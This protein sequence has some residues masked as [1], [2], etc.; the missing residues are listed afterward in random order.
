MRQWNSNKTHLL[1]L[2]KLEKMVITVFTKS[3]WSN[4]QGCFVLGSSDKLWK[5]FICIRAKLPLIKSHRMIFYCIGSECMLFRCNIFAKLKL[6]EELSLTDV[7]VKTTPWPGFKSVAHQRIW[8][9]QPAGWE[10]SGLPIRH[11]VYLTSAAHCWLFAD[12]VKLQIRVIEQIL[13]KWRGTQ[14]M[15]QTLTEAQISCFK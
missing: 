12:A 10:L 8:S 3:G 2:H 4:W 14:K 13:N 5:I 6:K 15:R 11:K 1:I 7:K 9:P